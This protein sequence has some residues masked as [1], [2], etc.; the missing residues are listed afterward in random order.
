MVEHKEAHIT[1]GWPEEEK[2]LVS[3]VC[4]TFNQAAYIGE[5]LESFL[6]QKTSFPFEIV[7]CND[8]STDETT[9]VVERYRQA[10]PRLIRHVVNETNQY[11]QGKRVVEL[12]LA[13]ARGAYVAL[14]EGDDYWTDPAKLETQVRF[15]ENNPEYVITYHR[16]QPFDEHGDVDIDFKGARRDLSAIELQRA[17]PLHTL[18]TCFRNLVRE[19]PPEFAAARFGDLCLWSLLGRYGKGKYLPDIAPAKYRVHG[20]GVFSTQSRR[21]RQGMASYT[22]SALAAYHSR[23]KDFD[24]AEYFKIRA[25]ISNLR[26][27]GLPTFVLKGIK[28][29]I[30]SR[31]NA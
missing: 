8:A 11:S 22:Y 4:P 20:E 17:T 13:H 3:I 15:L 28:L 24:N 27:I 7:V 23:I 10:Y 26:S 18:T 19:F 16:S 12:A 2:P 5:A 6:M 9:A 29:A 1:A 14:C 31:R 25:G 30:A 21:T